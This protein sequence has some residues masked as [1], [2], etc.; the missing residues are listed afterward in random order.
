MSAECPTA[1]VLGEKSRES[2]GTDNRQPRDILR[3]CVD[4]EQCRI[5][6][7][8]EGAANPGANLFDQFFRK[9]HENGE[10]LAM[11]GTSLRP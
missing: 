4:V 10:M 6:D 2:S 7:F 11:R 1:M 9:Q 8:S 5:Q 3:P